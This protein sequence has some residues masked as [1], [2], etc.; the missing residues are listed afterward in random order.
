MW[1]HD[2]INLSAS[3]TLWE[4]KLKC[5]FKLFQAVLVAVGS[6]SNHCANKDDIKL[7]HRKNRSKPIC[8]PLPKCNDGQEASVEPG[9]SHPLGTKIECIHCLEENFSNNHTNKRCRRCTSCGNKKE[10]SPCKRSGDRQCSHSC[11]SSEFYLNATDQQCYPCTECCGA[12]DEDI[13]HQCIS[14]RVSTVIGGNGEKHCKASFKS[15]QRCSNELPLKENS[16]LTCNSTF[17]A[18]ECSCGNSSLSNELNAKGRECRGS[19]DDLH[20][21]LICV[22]G[23]APVLAVLFCCHRYVSRRRSSRSGYNL[24]PCVPPCTGRVQIKYYCI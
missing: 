2:S 15:S 3:V 22:L 16:S 23:V 24:T 12:S 11:I 19:I 21:A 5:I 18:R 10:L 6:C 1:P 8:W 9:S 4:P 14:M 20:I 17:E 7:Y 13:E